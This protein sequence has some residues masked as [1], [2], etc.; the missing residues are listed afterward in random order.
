MRS[1]DE[2]ETHHAVTVFGREGAYIE[3]ANRGPHEDQG[4]A[5]GAVI[6]QLR[7]L[8]RDAAGCPRRRARIAVTHA[9]AIV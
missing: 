4:S 1:I 9:R 5:D 6:E 3:A 7:E 2:N 8:L